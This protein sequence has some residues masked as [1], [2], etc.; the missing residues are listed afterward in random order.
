MYLTFGIFRKEE[1][2]EK[3]KHAKLSF[4]KFV[5]LCMYD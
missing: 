4:Y 2:K 5:T 3:E 1:K